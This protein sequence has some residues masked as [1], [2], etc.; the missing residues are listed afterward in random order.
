[1]CVCICVYIL[2]ICRRSRFDYTRVVRAR[3][4]NSISYIYRSIYVYLYIFFETVIFFASDFPFFF[5]LH[6]FLISRARY[7][8]GL[9][10]RYSFP[11][12]DEDS[13]SN[14]QANDDDADEITHNFLFGFS[15]DANSRG[16]AQL[17]VSSINSTRSATTHPMLIVLIFSLAD[18]FFFFHYYIYFFFSLTRTCGLNSLNNRLNFRVPA[19]VGQ[20]PHYISVFTFS[21][22]CVLGFFLKAR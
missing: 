15:D 17:F 19:E 3:R 7:I 2:I 11:P 6:S 9:V 22:C 16:I 20:T 1:M 14:A 18:F 13:K 10:E 12:S 21:S 5:F 8:R 4:L